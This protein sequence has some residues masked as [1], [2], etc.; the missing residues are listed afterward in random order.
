MKTTIEDLSPWSGILCLWAEI[1]SQNAVSPDRSI[2]LTQFQPK[3]QLDFVQKQTS[4][5][6]KLCSKEKEMEQPW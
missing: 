1:Y 4:W 6:Q 2:G 5:I 3:D